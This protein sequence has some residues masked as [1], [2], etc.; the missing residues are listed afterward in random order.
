[1]D[2]VAGRFGCVAAGLLNP[3]P[4]GLGGALGPLLDRLRSTAAGSNLLLLIALLGRA[5]GT[6]IGTRLGVLRALGSHPLH[7]LATGAKSGGAVGL[8]CAVRL[9]LDHSVERASHT[10]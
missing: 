10:I 2:R 1:L 5:E 7:G 3:L 6:V 8:L 4:S 9:A